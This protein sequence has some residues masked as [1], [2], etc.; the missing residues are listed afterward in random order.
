MNKN[1]INNSKPSNDKTTID[2]SNTFQGILKN[3]QLRAINFITHSAVKIPI[4]PRLIMP[5]TM[6]V[7]SD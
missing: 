4:K 7:C 3:L 5:S 1:K 2:M 6:S